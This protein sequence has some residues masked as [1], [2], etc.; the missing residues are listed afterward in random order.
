M[1]RRAI[2]TALKNNKLTHPQRFFSQKINNHNEFHTQNLVQLGKLEREGLQ[3]PVCIAYFRSRMFLLNAAKA[4]QLELDTP[5]DKQLYVSRKELE[6]Y[7]DPANLLF[8][9]GVQESMIR[10]PNTTIEDHQLQPADSETLR[11][12]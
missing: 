10:F 6:A 2:H 5:N 3:S 9:L 12:I 8:A 1:L 7:P 4:E 11:P